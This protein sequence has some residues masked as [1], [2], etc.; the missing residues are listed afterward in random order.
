MEPPAE[1]PATRQDETEPMKDETPQRKPKRKTRGAKSSKSPPTK[2][3]TKQRTALDPDQDP[4]PRVSS[5]PAVRPDPD[6]VMSPPAN[7]TPTTNKANPSDPNETAQDLTFAEIAALP[8]SPQPNKII[9]WGPETE[10]P[11]EL[12]DCRV[13]IILH[14]QE[15]TNIDNFWSQTQE[16]IQVAITRISQAY[17]LS[18]LNEASIGIAPWKEDSDAPIL[19]KKEDIPILIGGQSTTGR[20]AIQTYF[21]RIGRP[22]IATPLILRNKPDEYAIH[23]GIRLRLIT[24]STDHEIRLLEAHL[25]QLYQVYKSIATIDGIDASKGGKVEIKGPLPCQAYEYAT[26]G[27]L[28]GTTKSMDS[29]VL[30][31]EVARLADI[32]NWIQLGGEWKFIQPLEAKDKFVPTPRTPQDKPRPPEGIHILAPRNYA[33]RVESAIADVF[34]K[35]NK[36]RPNG[37][38]LRAVP[39]FAHL[40]FASRR[41]TQSTQQTMVR[42][43]QDQQDFANY[44]TRT[45]E[46]SYIA[47]LDYEIRGSFGAITLRRFLLRMNPSTSL[48]R[49]IVVSV[50]AHWNRPGI[51]VITYNVEFAEEI[52]QLLDRMIPEAIARYGREAIRPWFTDYG[53]TMTQD[54][55][56][57]VA[58]GSLEAKRSSKTRYEFTTRGDQNNIRKRMAHF[59]A[60]NP[61]DEAT[62]RPEDQTELITFVQADKPSVREEELQDEPSVGSAWGKQRT[63]AQQKAHNDEIKKRNTSEQI[64]TEIEFDPE[65]IQ[66]ERGHRRSHSNGTGVQSDG[67]SKRL[68]LAAKTKEVDHLTARNDDLIGILNDLGIDPDDYIRGKAEAMEDDDNFLDDDDDDNLGPSNMDKRQIDPPQEERD[69]ADYDEEDPGKQEVIDA[70]SSPAPPTQAGAMDAGEVT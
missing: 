67:T 12:R 32:P 3:A 69:D 36:L 34:G 11:N 20:M 46:T 55:T 47:G 70:I 8:A 13:R 56:F 16:Q 38:P 24:K 54:L 25:A 17:D 61:T 15:G 9:Q 39:C 65:T 23:L 57:N 63:P 18:R 64:E 48:T 14:Y 2:V 5:S 59:R 68:Q 53:L 60:K 31:K 66:K 28:N 10:L 49:R 22:Q 44:L 26:I 43:R 27:Y 42:L 40:K 30:I 6:Q 50:D 51:H 41:I 62:E 4:K 1:T 7:N 35:N 21:G 52:E 58:Q 33:E 45:T 29:R 19:R 37:I